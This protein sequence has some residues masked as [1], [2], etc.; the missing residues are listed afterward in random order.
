MGPA[1]TPPLPDGDWRARAAL[2]FPLRNRPRP[3]AACSTGNAP[4]PAASR[5]YTQVRQHAGSAVGRALGVA[6]IAGALGLRAVRG[7]AAT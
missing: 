5:R 6:R 4:T 2:T 7:R 1:P 3:C